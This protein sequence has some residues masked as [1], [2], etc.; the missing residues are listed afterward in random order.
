[1]STLKSKHQLFLNCNLRELFSLSTSLLVGGF[2]SPQRRG[3]PASIKSASQV[4]S[5]H[6][7]CVP[8]SDATALLR[9]SPTFQVVLGRGGR[10]SSRNAPPSARLGRCARLLPFSQMSWSAIFQRHR[11]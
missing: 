3:N 1:M 4:V 5:L 6:S 10:M 2:H 7:A 9:V 8:D 11:G